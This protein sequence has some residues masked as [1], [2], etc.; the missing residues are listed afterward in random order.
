[1]LGSRGPHGRPIFVSPNMPRGP[2][3]TIKKGSWLF[4]EIYCANRSHQTTYPSARGIRTQLDMLGF[5]FSNLVKLE[6]FYIYIYILNIIK[7]SVK[8]VKIEYFSTYVENKNK[9]R[10]NIFENK[11]K[12][13][14]LFFLRKLLI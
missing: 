3:S 12:I 14:N 13:F 11:L 4:W 1:M 6:C 9:W 10:K 5:L 8:I 2:I 7:N